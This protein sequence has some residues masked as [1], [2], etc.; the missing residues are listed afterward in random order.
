M[1][2]PEGIL[3]GIA[4]RPGVA[5][6]YRVVCAAPDVVMLAQSDAIFYELRVQFLYS[7][8]LHLTPAPA[9]VLLR[10]RQY[11]VYEVP[12]SIH[13]VLVLSSDAENEPSFLQTPH[14]Q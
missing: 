9:R 3:F 4:Y 8:H 12:Y 14:H 10:V 1:P 11:H 7:M 2:D 13:D 5:P 6:V